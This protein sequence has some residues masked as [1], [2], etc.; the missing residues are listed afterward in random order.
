MK[1]RQL[2]FWL[3]I[4]FGSLVIASCSTQDLTNEST[5]ATKHDDHFDYADQKS[6]VPVSGKMQS[7]INIQTNKIQKLTPDVGEISLNYQKEQLR[8]EDNGH[9]IQVQ[10]SG[11]AQINQRHFELTQFHFH[12]PSE[13]TIDQRY[14]PLE[15]HFVHLA[16]NGRLAVIGVFFE[17]GKENVGFQE[18]LRNVENEEPVTLTKLA[19]LLP[20]NQSY[21][22]YLGSLTT[23]PLT[24]NVEWYI[25]KTPVELSAGQI[26]AF[27]QLYS[28]NNRNVQPLN[29]R[30]V[31]FHE[32]ASAGE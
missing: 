18:I 13:H 5:A 20:D 31:L 12:A 10:G 16:Q 26:K 3:F 27:E 30:V 32:E 4:A 22:H 21:Y 17:V 19:D 7:P 23:P 2:W 15:A 9:S 1:K 14:F 8:I 29:E 6:W 28:E 11:H 25:M 24:E